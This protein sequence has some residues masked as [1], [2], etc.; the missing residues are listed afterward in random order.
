M[1]KFSVRFCG[2]SK[3]NNGNKFNPASFILKGRDKMNI[4][5]FIHN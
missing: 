4:S 5:D 2:F 3:Q 1:N